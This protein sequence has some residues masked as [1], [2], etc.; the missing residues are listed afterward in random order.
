MMYLEAASSQ[1]INSFDKF[2]LCLADASKFY[3]ILAQVLIAIA[4]VGRLIQVCPKLLQQR[5][6]GSRL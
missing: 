3:A 2:F 5:L 1:A 6:L 4:V